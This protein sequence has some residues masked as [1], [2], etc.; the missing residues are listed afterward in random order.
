M[1]LRARS[2]LQRDQGQEPAA[3]LRGGA[4]A[5]ARRA[6]GPAD[7]GT[8]RGAAISADASGRL[9]RRTRRRAGA[10]EGPAGILPQ[11]ALPPGRHQRAR[12]RDR[13]MNS[14]NNLLPRVMI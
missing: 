13:G 14:E 7:A 3:V 10:T 8:R 9:V 11:A 2:F 5:L 4:R 6:D 1:V 12:L